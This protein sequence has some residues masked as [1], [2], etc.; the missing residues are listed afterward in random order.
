MKIL[1]L[2]ANFQNT[3]DLLEMGTENNVLFTVTPAILFMHH[4]TNTYCVC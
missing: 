2:L 3:I 1:E 4:E